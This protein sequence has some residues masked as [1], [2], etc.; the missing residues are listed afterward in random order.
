MQNLT[1]ENIWCDFFIFKI[2]NK[3]QK[4]PDLEM[5]VWF[6]ENCLKWLYGDWIYYTIYWDQTKWEKKEK[7][8][9]Y[10]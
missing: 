3:K 6:N 1:D 4:L 10:E 2:Q 5:L 8:N 7:Q 9:E